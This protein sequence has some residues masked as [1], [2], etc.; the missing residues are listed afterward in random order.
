MIF[1]SWLVKPSFSA[2][3]NLAGTLTIK[4]VKKHINE[5]NKT[6]TTTFG[7]SCVNI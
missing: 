6:E 5:V 4:L 3:F 1:S 2:F 7:N